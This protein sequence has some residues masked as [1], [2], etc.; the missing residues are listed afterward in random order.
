MPFEPFDSIFTVMG[1]PQA[2]STFALA[3][4]M[5]AHVLLWNEYKH[6]DSI[7]MLEDLLALA[8]GERMEIR[9]PH[10]VNQTWRNT[11]PLIFTSNSPLTVFREDP[12][13]MARLNV[14]M[15]ERFC[16]R[17]WHNIIPHEHRE[18]QFPKCPRCC[19]TF[20]LMYR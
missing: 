7:V 1:K 17:T 10:A 4:V 8:A 12:G 5:A 11:A 19:A 9:V 2:G 20:F 13:S 15:G 14:A 6:K 3:N 16:T 18:P